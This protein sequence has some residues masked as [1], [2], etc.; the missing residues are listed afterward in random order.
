MDVS[1]LQSHIA[2]SAGQPRNTKVLTGAGTIIEILKV[3]RLIE[4]RDGRLI[5]VA[6]S[7]TDTPGPPASHEVDRV[8][9]P[10]LALKDEPVPSRQTGRVADIQIH[11]QIVCR[12]EDLPNLPSSIRDLLASLAEQSSD[13]T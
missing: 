3:A 13:S 11:I 4:D 9:T 6:R 12:P 1:T 10:R 2:Y 5:A 8:E 7:Q